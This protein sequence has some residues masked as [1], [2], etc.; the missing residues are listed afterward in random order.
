[1][2]QP[3][4]LYHWTNQIRSMFP[5]LSKPQAEVLAAFSFGVAKAKSC[6][7]NAVARGLAFLGIPDTV[8]TRLRRFISNPRIDM[9]ESCESL[10][11]NVIR[12]MPRKKPVIL[13][14]DETSLQDKL[15]AMVVSVACAGRA[16][17]GGDDDLSSDSV[18]DGTGRN[19][20]DDAQMGQG[21]SGQRQRPDRDGGQRHRNVSESSQGDRRSWD[22]L[23]DARVQ[24]RPGADG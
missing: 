4:P 7:L 11:R 15:K 19:D 10:A 23:H 1:M 12:A 24:D 18:A 6:A 17:R 16:V 2:S 14:V 13:P 21:R 9:A 8:E 22:A 3:K 20:S 5:N